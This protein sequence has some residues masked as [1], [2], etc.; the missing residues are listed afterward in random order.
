MPIPGTVFQVIPEGGNHFW[1]VIS[2][3]I[4]GNVLVVNI[5]DADHCPDSTC[6]LHIG[7]HPIIT[8][9]SVVYYR[10]SREFTATAIDAQIAEGTMVRKLDDCSSEVLNRIIEGARKQTILHIVF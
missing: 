8:K 9:E 10:K 4:N 5:T 7:D 2:K 1:V 3:P 6:T